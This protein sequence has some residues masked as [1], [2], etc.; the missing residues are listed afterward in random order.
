MSLFFLFR[1]E[2]VADQIDDIVHSFLGQAEFA[3]E[4][5]DE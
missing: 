5:P 3:Q 1:T 4:D 2:K